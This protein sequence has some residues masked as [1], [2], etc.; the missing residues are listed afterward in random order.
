MKLNTISR[1][2]LCCAM[3]S[4][5]LVA[6]PA[7]AADKTEITLARFFGACEA[8]YGKVT[9]VSK[10]RGECGI[11]TS[12]VNQFNASNK[13]G[14]VVKPEIAEW[15]PYYDQLTS[16][17]V[18]HNVPT[19]AVMHQSVLGD[20][21]ARKLVDPLD[22]GFRKVGIDTGAFTPQA[23]RGVIIGGKT[24]ALPFDTWSWLW[25]I[26]TR[27]FKQAGLTHPDGSPVI[28]KTPAELLA[29]A[30]K[31]KAA[32]GKPYFSWTT[33]NETAAPTRT[34][35]TLVYQ[36]NGTL[37]SPDGRKIN[38]HTTAAANALTLMNTLWK[39][40][41]IKKGL[42]YGAT[43]QAF[44]NGEAAVDVVGNW[45]IDD[46]Y[47]AS[48]KAG[49]PLYKSYDVVPFANLYARPAVFADGHS[50]V[51]IRGGAKTDKEK[52]AALVF[53]KFLWDHDYD[54]SRTGHLPANNAVVQ[55]A[56][57]KALPFRANIIGIT[58]YGVSTPNNVPRQR[59]IEAIVGEEISSMMLSGKAIPAVQNAIETRVNTLLAGGK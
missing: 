30:R 29:Q 37:F 40:G 44:L 52:H 28:P 33:A 46:F 9:D 10:A 54:W 43:Q 47:T 49:S 48:Q 19:V 31:L 57:Y 53:M 58:R 15:G 6:T 7:R 34:F 14:I 36:Q 16:R 8:D 32:T 1:G 20:F 2:L 27:L 22:D 23:R 24:Y 41:D 25:H 3:G 5:A 11:I 50:W 39:E 55:S 26:N 38:V 13:E 18:A 21:V 17:I 59:A 42:D 56:Q 35:L 12:L 4:A 45:T 51:M